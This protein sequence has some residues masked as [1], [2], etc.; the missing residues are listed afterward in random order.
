M[1]LD[2]IEA[3]REDRRNGALWPQPCPSLM[4]V[5]RKTGLD[6]T[7]CDNCRGAGWTKATLLDTPKQ[8]QLLAKLDPS[9]EPHIQ[10]D[11]CPRCDGA[12]GFVSEPPSLR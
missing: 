8:I 5:A 2:Q 11:K 6:F 4:Q 10:Y 9:G 3:A 12:G 7:Q 1:T